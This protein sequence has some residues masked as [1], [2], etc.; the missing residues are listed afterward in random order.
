VHLL[1][2]PLKQKASRPRRC[3]TPNEALIAAAVKLEW[4][5]L[6]M[7]TADDRFKLREMA[8]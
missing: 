1:H 8:M 3:T 5:P 7:D 2:L 4:I 6:A